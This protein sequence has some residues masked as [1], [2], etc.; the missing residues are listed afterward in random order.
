[1]NLGWKV[2][3]VNRG[4]GITRAKSKR[5]K[6]KF[7]R[8]CGKQTTNGQLCQTCSDFIAHKRAEERKRTK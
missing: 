7:C 4:K 8:I 1:M 2:V 5:D 6:I 3:N